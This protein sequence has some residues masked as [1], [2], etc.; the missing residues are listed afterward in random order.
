[1]VH[2]PVARPASASAATAP[3]HASDTALLRRAQKAKKP[4]RL[5][6]ASASAH[7]RPKKAKYIWLMA[8]WSNRKN[9]TKP[10]SSPAYSIS[11]SPGR[12]KMRSASRT[13]PKS[14]SGMAA[15]A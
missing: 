13:P 8:S 14:A 7:K 1:M 11:L 10:P 6:T 4:G 12:R 5:C 9:A 3:L 15:G 2:N